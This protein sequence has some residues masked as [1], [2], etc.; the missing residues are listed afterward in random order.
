MPRLVP[1]ALAALALAIAPAT[2]RAESPVTGSL[3]LRLGTFRPN[4]DADFATTPG[5]YQ[6]TFGGKRPL[7]WDLL[8][9]KAL[10]RGFGTVEAGLGVGFFRQNGQGL[11]LTGP[12]AGQPSGDKTTFNVV[13]TSLALT[14]R[15]DV[16]MERWNVPV[17]PFGRASL[18]RYNWWVTNGAGST[19]QTGATNGYSYGAGLGLALDFFDPTLG[20]E[21]DTETGV[22]HTMAVVE[23]KKTVI[24]DFGSAKSWDLSDTKTSLSFGLLFVF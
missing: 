12:L 7:K 14:W 6:T 8:A 15:L 22:N 4:V 10:W 16:L 17:I 11:F 19:V 13:P 2:A 21:L 20:R 23:L 18:E 5:P 24:D 3:E 9:S 1:A